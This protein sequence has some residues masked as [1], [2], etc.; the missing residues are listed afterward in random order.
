MAYFKNSEGILFEFEDSVLILQPGQ[1]RPLQLPKGKTSIFV[2]KEKLEKVTNVQVPT[3]STKN[4]VE[5]VESIK[6]DLLNEL[7]QKRKRV[8]STVIEIDNYLWSTSLKNEIRLT[9]ALKTLEHQKEISNWKTENGY[10]TLTKELAEKVLHAIME[11]QSKVFSTEA[12]KEKEI[13]AIKTMKSLK[14]YKAQ[15]KLDTSWN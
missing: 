5:T 7:K 9:N 2:S 14:A 13:L 4:T 8:E 6:Q 11:H 10:V 3:L 12:K 15:G 1:K